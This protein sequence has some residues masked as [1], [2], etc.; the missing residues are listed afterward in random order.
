[1]ENSRVR[2]T[3]RH[4]SVTEFHQRFPE[5]ELYCFAGHVYEV[6]ALDANTGQ[7]LPACG[8]FKHMTVVPGPPT[9]MRGTDYK[10]HEGGMDIGIISPH[11][12]RIYAAYGNNYEL[13]TQNVLNL[14]QRL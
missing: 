2:F 14:N 7:P 5:D 13:L 4:V 9:Y 3:S 1:M 12:E 11:A 10:I 6:I 8:A